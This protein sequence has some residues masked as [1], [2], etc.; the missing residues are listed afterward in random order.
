MCV[1]SVDDLIGLV[2]SGTKVKYLRF[3]GHRPQR[4]GAVG[5]GCLSQWWP[6][7]FTVDGRT[8]PTAEHYMMWRK[9]T[10]FGDTETAD[11]ILRAAHP[12]QAKALGRTVRDFDE[13]AWTAHRY[14]IVV[15]GSAAKFSQHGD[16]KTYLL[17][18]GSRVLVEAS[19]VDRVWGIGLTADDPRAEDPSQWRGLNL[20]G[21][22][23]MDARTTLRESQW[24]GD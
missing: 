1:R 9:A 5:A 17:S 10:L 18:T 4:D 8:F 12:H 11:R 6:A 20:L 16:L 13:S 24:P 2:E 19:P 15:T 3:W 22:A 23:L 14:Q 7:A 21:F